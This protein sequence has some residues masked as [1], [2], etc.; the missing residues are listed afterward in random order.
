MTLEEAV[1]LG[2]NDIIVEH[3]SFMSSYR[4]NHY[5]IVDIDWD[6]LELELQDSDG[7]FVKTTM[8]NMNGSCWFKL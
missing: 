3:E 7:S 4:S 8:C 5:L 6:N 1:T 2:P